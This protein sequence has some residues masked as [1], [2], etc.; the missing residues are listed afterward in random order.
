MRFVLTSLI[1]CLVLYGIKA[2]WST[3]T[4]PSS[5]SNCSGSEEYSLLST[6]SDVSF[7]SLYNEKEVPLT[8]PEWLHLIEQLNPPGNLDSSFIVYP[9][10]D[11]SC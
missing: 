8:Y 5:L 9:V 7:Q 3:P 4:S 6:S 10:W 1:I 11:S 2:D